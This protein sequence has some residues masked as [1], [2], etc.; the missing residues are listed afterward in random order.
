MILGLDLAKSCKWVLD[1]ESLVS[2][3]L[4][5]LTG[6]A[7]FETDALKVSGTF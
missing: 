3:F 5:T 2:C 4:R 6:A 1:L 7:N